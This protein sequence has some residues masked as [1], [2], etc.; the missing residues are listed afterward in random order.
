V[1]IPE[2]SSPSSSSF[3]SSFEPSPQKSHRGVVEITPPVPDRAEK[4]DNNFR[5]LPKST[6]VRNKEGLA[7]N[8][9]DEEEEEANPHWR[10]EWKGLVPHMEEYKANKAQIEEYRKNP[11]V[12][13]IIRDLLKKQPIVC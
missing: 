5:S 10:K 3:Q 4:S 11:H 2:N 12:I 9:E 13:Y 1:L 6:P 7:F 8:L